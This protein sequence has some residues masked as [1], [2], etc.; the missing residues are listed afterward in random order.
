LLKSGRK[1]VQAPRAHGR[2]SPQG[3]KKAP[4]PAIQRA[5]KF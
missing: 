4:R 2:M 3:D 1:I 5:M